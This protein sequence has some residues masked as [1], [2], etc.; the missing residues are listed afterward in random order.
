MQNSTTGLLLL[1]AVLHIQIVPPCIS[2]KKKKLTREYTTGHLSKHTQKTQKQNKT[3][4]PRKGKKK[5]NTH[6]Q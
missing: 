5:N 4:K 6:W 3:T 1:F 2:I